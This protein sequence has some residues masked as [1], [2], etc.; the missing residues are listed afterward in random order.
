MKLIFK[1]II[2]SNTSS[3]HSSCISGGACFFISLGASAY[4]EPVGDS[5]GSVR[6]TQ[7]RASTDDTAS[8][9]VATQFE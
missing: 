9:S 8:Y 2:M 7:V 5:E 3:S 4:T 1:L 6:P